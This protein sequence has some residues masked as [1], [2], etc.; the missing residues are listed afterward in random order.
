M[1]Q[2]DV[3]I[4]VKGVKS[5]LNS[6]LTFEQA[7]GVL[8]DLSLRVVHFDS[9]SQFIETKMRPFLAKL[10]EQQ[11]L[12]CNSSILNVSKQLHIQKKNQVSA[13][14]SAHLQTLTEDTGCQ[15]LLKMLRSVVKSYFT[16][17]S[18]LK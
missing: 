10:H 1:S 8:E 17:Y 13:E 16:V 7:V 4:A 5:N 6:C 14:L 2:K 12:H 9:F 11:A 15:K 18:N 3:D